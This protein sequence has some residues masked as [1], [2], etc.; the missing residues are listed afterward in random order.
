MVHLLKM[1]AGIR[2][3]GDLRARQDF[4]VDSLK[5]Q[6]KPAEL[7]H[8]T[9][10]MPKRASELRGKGSLYWVFNKA[11]Q[12]RQKIIDLRPVQSP[13]GRTRCAIVLARPIIKVLAMPRKAFQGWRYLEYDDTPHD[14]KRHHDISMDMPME[15][16]L[17]L[18]ELCLI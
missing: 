1:A 7:L 16:R 6:G 13:D 17:A 10:F 2:S 12:A 11:I 9:R 18:T 5:M 14:I 15:M 3:L 4:I 8:I